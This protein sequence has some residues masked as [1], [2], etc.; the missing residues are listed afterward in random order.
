[1]SNYSK[2]SLALTLRTTLELNHTCSPVLR[3]VTIR[4]TM[5]TIQTQTCRL[6]RRT[7]ST[8]NH[9]ESGGCIGVFV[10]ASSAGDIGRVSQFYAKVMGAHSQ[11]DL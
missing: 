9:P 1:M 5:S 2:V 4:S 11:S 7:A 3:T 6:V 8:T 10:S